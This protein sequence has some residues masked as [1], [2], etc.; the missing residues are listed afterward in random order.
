MSGIRVTQGASLS[1][2]QLQSMTKG[3]FEGPTFHTNPPK[4]VIVIE[5]RLSL[6]Y[7][8]TKQL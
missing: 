8:I 2:N 6:N 7:A 5:G 1:N 4:I 3:T